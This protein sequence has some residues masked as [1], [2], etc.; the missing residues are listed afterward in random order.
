MIFRHSHAMRMRGLESAR[1]KRQGHAIEPVIP[2]Q[3]KPKPK[4]KAKLAA[5]RATKAK[6][7]LGWE[8]EYQLS[9]LVKEMMKSDLKL[10]Q[11]QQYLKE[12]GY[13]T[14]NYFE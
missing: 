7:K 11:K 9:D 3:A 14:L 1:A 10:M 6:V 12:G 5:K 8:P 13:N 2:R 4:T